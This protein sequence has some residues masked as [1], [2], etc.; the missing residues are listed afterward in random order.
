MPPETT[1]APNSLVRSKYVENLLGVTAHTLA[2]WRSTGRYNLPF[3]KVGKSVRYKLAD[4]HAFLEE[5][6][7]Q[8]MSLT[9][10]NKLSQSK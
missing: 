10:R 9:Q 4:V 2:V 7:V 6:T 8:R 1:L 3:V 5:R